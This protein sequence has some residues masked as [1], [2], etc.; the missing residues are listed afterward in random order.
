[1][2]KREKAHGSNGDVP[3]IDMDTLRASARAADLADK[4]H[5]RSSKQQA[6]QSNHMSDSSSPVEHAKQPPQHHQGSFQ[7][8]PMMTSG[9]TVPPEA[10]PIQVQQA[11][12]V[13]APPNSASMTV[14]P[15]PWATPAPPVSGGRGYAPDQL[16]H[17]SFMRTSQHAKS[18]HTSPH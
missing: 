4:T 16:Q 8:V 2:R 12:Q 6:S 1:M 5:S 9:P 7:L 11:Q 18:N 14:P 13:M 15:S 17:Q 3:R 10:G